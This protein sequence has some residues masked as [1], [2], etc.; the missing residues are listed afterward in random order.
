M[1]APRLSLIVV[2]DYAYVNGGAAQVAIESA[3]MM[4][5]AGLVVT[6]FAGVPPIDER[7]TA[8]NITTITV[9][10]FDILSHPSRL[11]AASQGIWNRQAAHR[12][13][14]L[15]AATDRSD[16][17]IHLHGWSKVLSAS[18]VDSVLEHRIPMVLT[19]HDYFAA[20]PNGGFFNYQTQQIC[21]L[22]PLSLDCVCTDCDARS[23]PQKLW[24]VAR[25]AV[26]RNIGLPGKVKD[27]IAVS[28]F[29]RKVMEPYLPEGA[30][31]FDISNPI[32]VEQSSP[33][34]IHEN[35]IFLYVGRLSPE[36]GIVSL[37]EAA[38]S[39]RVALRV[40]GDGPMRAALQAKYPETEFTGWVS[41]AQVRDHMRSARAL[42][43]PSLWYESQG[44]VVLEAVALG[45]PAIV[46]RTS[47]ASQYVEDSVSGFLTESGNV[48]ELSL[49][50]RELTD[51]TL[52]RRLGKAAH[53]RYWLAPHT[54]E[55]HRAA[56]LACYHDVFSHRG[57]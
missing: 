30:R 10:D 38:R 8:R 3:C 22:R 50:L 36:K 34:E 48:A 24:R 31:I 49:R 52:A 23:Y 42:I 20:C 9:S 41:S 39:A 40:V 44:M 28:P 29:S 21:P 35:A 27:F 11:S 7:L 37:L 55:R 54:A 1:T 56:L 53:Q 15:L 6:F 2:N 45:L 4:H 57:N 43:F 51:T 12:L 14:L 5:D 32:S 47:A 46:S 33:V 26:E 18:V 19:M 17:I 25:S 16:T 13:N